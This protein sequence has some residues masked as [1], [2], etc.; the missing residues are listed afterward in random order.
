MLVPNDAEYDF[1]GIYEVSVYADR[2]NIMCEELEAYGYTVIRP[3]IYHSR[4]D[5]NSV[6]FIIY[7]AAS[8]LII[9]ALAF[10]SNAILQR[11]YNT[12]IKQYT[13][14]RSLGVVK[15]EM[16]LIVLLEFLLIATTAIILAFIAMY[17]LYFIF[18]F[19]FLNVIIFNN[20]IVTLIYFAVMFMFIM[21]IVSRFNKRLYQ[22]SVQSTFKAEVSN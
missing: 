13:V 8:T 19:E 18:K 22:Y 4:V 5:Q 14:F 10:I 21:Y 12:K 11:V 9:F 6:L 7:V 3:S 2:P 1:G 16:N 15:K 17:A 20:A